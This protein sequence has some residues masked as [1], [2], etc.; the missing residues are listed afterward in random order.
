MPLKGNPKIKRI[1]AIPMRCKLT[2]PF[3][4][5]QGWHE[6]RKIVLVK[7]VTDNGIEGYGECYGPIA[8][9]RE[10]VE[11]FLAP[12][13]KGRNPLEIERLW[14]LMYK[15]TRAAFQSFVPIT[16]I[17]GIDV[18]LWDIKGKILGMPIYKLLGNSG[19]DRI[20]AYAT[21]HYF[22]KTNSVEE[23]FSHIITEALDNVKAGFD[24]L[25][26]KIGLKILGFSYKED[27]ELVY[28]VREAIGKK[29]AL[30][31][32]ANYVYDLHTAILVGKEL[33]KTQIFW[34]EEPIDPIDLEGY[35]KLKTLLN[36]PIA[37]GECLA[38]R[39]GFRDFISQKAIDIAQP[40]IC[41]A[42]GITEC[43][44]IADMA[45]TYNIRFV[46]H[47]WGSPV[48]IAACLQL[49]ASL[50]KASLL[51]LDR[52]D[53]PIREEMEKSFIVKEGSYVK[54][55]QNPGLGINID[56]GIITK[57]RQI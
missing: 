30:M 46:P 43:R 25:K 8:G 5:S 29:I 23:L 19:C 26:L 2:E 35:K 21:G 15:A 1:E 18:A 28:K 37:A 55:P 42:G 40:D 51:E 54:V 48:A 17:S 53:N 41:A 24:M 3:G 34:F 38:T 56:E 13:L 50:P 39:Y 57:Y 32:D 9:N 14:E 4:Y 6:E 11:D 49:I 16:A 12:L 44:K 45:S 22:K 33:E 20:K 10:I 7:I 47:V 27:I 31:V 52:S 36:I